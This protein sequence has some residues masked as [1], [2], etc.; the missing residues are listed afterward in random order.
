MTLDKGMTQAIGHLLAKSAVIEELN[1]SNTGLTKG[2]IAPIVDGLKSN[3]SS[4]LHTIDVSHNMMGD[5][6]MPLLGTAIGE[7][8]KGL[9]SLNASNCGTRKGGAAGFINGLRKN[10][11][12]SGSMHKI[13]LSNNVLDSDG[14]VALSGFLAQ[15]TGLQILNVQNC[16]IKLDQLFAALVRGCQNLEWFAFFYHYYYYYYYYDYLLFSL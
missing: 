13:D 10:M 11:F 9:I 12:M 7:M 6:D 15:P 4:V 16:A 14:T 3:P 2:L 8:P 1:L 5:K